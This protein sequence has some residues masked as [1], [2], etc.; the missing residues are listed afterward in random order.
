MKILSKENDKYYVQHKEGSNMFIIKQNQ[1][2]QEKDDLF[3]LILNLD[4]KLALTR[5]AKNNR[6]IKELIRLKK[7]PVNFLKELGEYVE[8]N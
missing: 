5:K 3:N 1:N 8:T 2:H 4:K 7:R 6:K